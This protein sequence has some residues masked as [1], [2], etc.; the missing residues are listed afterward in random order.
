M[1]CKKCGYEVEETEVFCANC[2][3]KINCIDT[4]S[5]QSKKRSL[6]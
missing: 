3:E 2:G 6:L 1:K 4:S 5:T